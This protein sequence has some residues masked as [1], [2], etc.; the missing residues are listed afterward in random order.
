MNERVK[1]GRKEGRKEGGAV[2]FFYDW[3]RNQKWLQNFERLTE[4]K[5]CIYGIIMIRGYG[6]IPHLSS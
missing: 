4:K 3:S 2:L 1:E 5:L 6:M